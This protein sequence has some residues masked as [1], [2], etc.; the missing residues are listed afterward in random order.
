MSQ[1]LFK[2]DNINWRSQLRQYLNE[3]LDQDIPIITPWKLIG[4][5]IPLHQA[6]RIWLS[7]SE[8]LH[9]SDN[10]MRWKT[11]VN[12]L[13]G[14]D[15][16]YTPEA[17]NRITFDHYIRA[18]SKPCEYCQKPFFATKRVR[19]CGRSCAS[20]NRMKALTSRRL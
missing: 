17:S 12:D 8:T 16:V 6:T 9:I 15:L 4:L 14:Y 19:F 1:T 7:H 5:Y 10:K 13:S 3:H 20:K 2:P 11:F 18:V